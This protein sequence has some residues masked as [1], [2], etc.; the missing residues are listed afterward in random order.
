[1]GS[2]FAS[3][4]A[5]AEDSEIIF[6]KKIS[7]LPYMKYQM[8]DSSKCQDA[9]SLV[10]NAPSLAD[11][12]SNK[13]RFNI[14]SDWLKIDSAKWASGCLNRHTK[15]DEFKEFIDYISQNQKILATG[16]NIRNLQ[17]E[18]GR[19]E[20]ELKSTTRALTHLNTVVSRVVTVKEK[21]KSCG[22]YEAYGNL[23]FINN[24]ENNF[25]FFTGL[26]LGYKKHSFDKSFFGGELT[27]TISRLSMNNE[28]PISFTLLKNE[29]DIWEAEN[30]SG[31][32]RGKN[33]SISKIWNSA[34]TEIAIIGARK[35]G[36]DLLILQQSQS[37]DTLKEDVNNL[38]TKISNA[39]NELEKL[40]P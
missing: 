30:Y 19:F 38:Q 2:I 28:H 24:T 12:H 27:L 11:F 6:P 18:I 26:C 23:K 5:M 25:S 22:S 3:T 39:K 40:A 34:R 14:H 20:R 29:N 15:A 7:Q 31:Y 37:L 32:Y 17:A 13:L 4:L 1:M 16:K 33:N 9:I 36:Q 10:N 21:V 8:Q 35:Y